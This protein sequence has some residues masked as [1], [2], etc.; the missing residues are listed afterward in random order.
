MPDGINRLGGM[1]MQISNHFM[2]KEVDLFRLDLIHESLRQGIELRHLIFKAHRLVG[3]LLQEGCQPL[4][5]F[6][7]LAGG[8]VDLGTK[9]GETCHFF[10]LREFQF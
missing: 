5:A 1:V 8:F 3:A 7:L 9:P 2:R 4:P 6:D 10:V